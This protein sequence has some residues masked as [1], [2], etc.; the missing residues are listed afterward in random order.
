MGIPFVPLMY[1]TKTAHVLDDLGYDRER[2]TAQSFDAEKAAKRVL[3]ETAFKLPPD[4]IHLAK[5]HVESFN[6]YIKQQS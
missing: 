5:R 1:S 2:F 4:T 6:E 3:A